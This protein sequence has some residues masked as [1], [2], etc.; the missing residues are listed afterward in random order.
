LDAP[1]WLPAA[2]QGA[3]GIAAREGDRDV[4]ELLSILDSPDVRRE[5]TAERTFL[6]ELEG[7]CQIPIGSIATV[8]GEAL[9]IDG[10]V[11]SLDGQT[12]IRG[13]IEAPADEPEEAGRRLAADLL[14]RGA[15]EVLDRVRATAEQSLPRASAP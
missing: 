7:G 5:T 12:L 14:E 10:F 4:A 13:R 3:L 9:R 8:A 1:A 6:R 15:K 11:G 2:G